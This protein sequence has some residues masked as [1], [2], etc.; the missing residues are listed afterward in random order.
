MDQARWMNLFPQD[1]SNSDPWK[2][3]GNKSMYFRVLPNMTDWM[4]LILMKLL[5]EINTMYKD[6]KEVNLLQEYCTN[7][8]KDK[9]GKAHYYWLRT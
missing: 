8:V 1:N 7:Q 9:Y 5:H 4:V 2:I 6:K 3:K